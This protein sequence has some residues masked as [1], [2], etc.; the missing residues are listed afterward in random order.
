M[1]AVLAMG[2]LVPLGLC[3]LVNIYTDFAF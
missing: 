3:L 1:L 2:T